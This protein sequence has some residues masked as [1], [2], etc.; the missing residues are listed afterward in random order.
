MTLARLI[1]ESWPVLVLVGAAAL[2]W[3][4]TREQRHKT[5]MAQRAAYRRAYMIEQTRLEEK[6]RILP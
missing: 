3:F 5:S 6:V 4:G 2:A 1:M